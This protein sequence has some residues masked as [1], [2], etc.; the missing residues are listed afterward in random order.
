MKDQEIEKGEFTLV[1]W[2]FSVF[3]FE[4]KRPKVDIRNFES[5]VSG[6]NGHDELECRSRWGKVASTK[7][8]GGGQG[9][10]DQLRQS[11]VHVNLMID[12]CVRVQD[13][14]SNG[15]RSRPALTD[16]SFG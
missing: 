16:N 1:I 11:F 4:Q 7:C 15:R 5:R 12:C 9:C 8:V 10:V 3:P 2:V 6:L 13:T 14:A